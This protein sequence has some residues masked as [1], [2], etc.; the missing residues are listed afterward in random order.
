[1]NQVKS[2]RLF[3]LAPTFLR[4]RHLSIKQNL[5]AFGFECGDGWFQLLLPICIQGEKEC[6]ALLKKGYPVS[7]T[8]IAFQVKEKFNGLRFYINGGSP[9]LHAIIQEME[10]KSYGINDRL[11]EADYDLKKIV[12]RAKEALDSL[13]I[14]LS[15][16]SGLGKLSTINAIIKGVPHIPYA[17]VKAGGPI[18]SVLK[19][20]PNKSLVKYAYRKAKRKG[21]SLT[22]KMA[23]KFA[24]STK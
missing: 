17:D 24:L 3:K 23:F 19:D 20:F 1:M 12:N 8:P 13:L 18:S 7:H 14:A 16:N 9:K 11:T 2:R 10:S 21:L 6:Q 15:P 4:G 5:M 22:E